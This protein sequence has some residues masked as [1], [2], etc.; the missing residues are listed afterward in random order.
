MDRQEKKRFVHDIYYF[1]VF[2]VKGW[3]AVMKK[4]ICEGHH[5]GR[6]LQQRVYLSH[7]SLLLY[8]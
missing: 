6:G 4:L 5:S 2:V 7:V 3:F 1:C 8:V